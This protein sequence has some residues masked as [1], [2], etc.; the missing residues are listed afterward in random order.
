[1]TSISLHPTPSPRTIMGEQVRAVG[2]ALRTEAILFV[3]A[4][5]VFAVILIAAAMRFAHAPQAVGSHMAY[6]YQLG[7]AIPMFLVGLLFPLGVWRSEDPARRAYHWSMPIARGAHTVMK[8]LA[9][10]LWLMMATAVFLLFNI[11]LASAVSLITGQTVS[12]SAAPAWIFIA[13]FTAPTIGYLLTSIP[14]IGSNHPWRWIG[15]VVIG[16]AVLIAAFRSFGMQEVSDA[17]NAI[18]NGTYGLNA[19]LLGL[20]PSGNRG[21]TREAIQLVQLHT[22]IAAMPLWLIG[23]AIAAVFTSYR[24][25][26]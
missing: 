19:G 1:M 8:M 5:I 13:A 23:S 7:G 16:L 9:G 20:T 11:G 18:F 10:W 14:V 25:R 6:Q 2:L 15:G 4:L 3:S 26:E 24:Y 17:L 21:M 12:Q 22:W